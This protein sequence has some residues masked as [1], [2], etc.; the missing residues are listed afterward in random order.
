MTSR[1]GLACRIDHWRRFPQVGP[2]SNE[3]NL[4]LVGSAL[5]YYTKPRLIARISSIDLGKGKI[6]QNAEIGP[7]NA[8]DPLPP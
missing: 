1:R 2:C 7:G 6:N 3:V 8:F 5:D 4:N